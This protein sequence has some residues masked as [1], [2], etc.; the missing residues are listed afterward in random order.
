M[1]Y[2]KV[3][4]DLQP[5][6]H[7]LILSIGAGGCPVIFRGFSMISSPSSILSSSALELEDGL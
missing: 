3:Q 5:L 2:K 7:P 1:P 6:L 4:Y